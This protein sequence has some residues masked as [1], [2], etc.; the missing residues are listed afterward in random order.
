MNST[1]DIFTCGLSEPIL[2][3]S[4]DHL[5]LGQ[6]DFECGYSIFDEPSLFPLN[7]EIDEW[8]DIT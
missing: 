8:A 7:Q 1:L 5:E 6:K 4:T 2:I 3:P